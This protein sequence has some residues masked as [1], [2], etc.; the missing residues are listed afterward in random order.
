MKRS[1]I[2][3]PRTATVAQGERW[4]ITHTSG[5]GFDLAVDGNYHGGYETL[6]QA[7]AAKDTAMLALVERETV[8]QAEPF[9]GIELEAAFGVYAIYLR[10]QLLGHVPTREGAE[11]ALAWAAQNKTTGEAGQLVAA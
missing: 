3:L 11:R 8:S 1:T 2:R 7:L 4:I 6:T 5:E 9:T 10:G